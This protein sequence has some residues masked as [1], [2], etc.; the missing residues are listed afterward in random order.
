MKRNPVKFP[1]M[2]LMMIYAL[3]ATSITAL[4]DSSDLRCSNRTIS[5]DYAWSAQGLV[6]TGPP[7]P[8]PFT[9]VGIANFDGNGKLSWV[10]H[11]VIGGQVQGSEW[12][13]ATGTYT[14]NAN[15]TGTAVVTTPNSQVP[16]HF[17][18]AISKQS[19]EVRT[20]VDGHSIVAVFT[21]VEDWR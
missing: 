20:T 11:T 5:G 21:K 4:A 18:L 14:V 15:C 10:E 9:S 7:Q 13:E 8:L 17:S 19:R 3:L 1:A 16:L 2:P 6:I 12:V